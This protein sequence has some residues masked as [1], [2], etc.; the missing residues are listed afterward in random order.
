MFNQWRKSALKSAFIFEKIQDKNFNWLQKI[1]IKIESE[2]I[3]CASL[4]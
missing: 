1:S 4:I 3:F 2:N